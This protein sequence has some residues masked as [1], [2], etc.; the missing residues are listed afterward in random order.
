MA[1]AILPAAGSSRRM[2]RPK[3][4]LPFRDTTVVG[5][6]VQ[7]LRE[8]GVSEIVIVTA[9]ADAALQA[10]GAAARLRVAVNAEPERGML[11]TLLAG[12]SSL[13]GADALARRGGHLAVSPADLPALR[14][15]TVTEILRRAATND[16]PLVVPTFQGRRG[17]PLVIAPRLIPEIATLDPNVGLKELILRHAAAVVEVE[18]GDPGAV[19]DVDT[20]EEYESLRGEGAQA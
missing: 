12:I 5:A 14:P 2:G 1:I 9:P 11:S 8:G 18:V 6:L 15:S 10:W 19:R 17:H 4:L 7:A 16:S 3:L 20:P 13:G